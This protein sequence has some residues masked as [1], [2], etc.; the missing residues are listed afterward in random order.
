MVKVLQLITVPLSANGLALYPIRMAERMDSR[1]Q[2]DFLAS[3]AE[4]ELQARI[5]KMGSRL[6]LAPSRLRSP[7]A[8][9]RFV[10]KTIE[11][12][13]YSIVHAHGNSCTLALDLIAARRGGAKVRIA[14]SHNTFCRFRALNFLLRPAF[15]RAY[16]HALACSDS[17]GKWLFR[18][19]PFAILPNAI[20]ARAFAPDETVR[21]RIRREM[22]A[23]D[24]RIL[25]HI[26]NFTEAKNPLFF[27]D[28][29]AQL[30]RNY[31]LWM[32]GDGP[33]RAEAERLAREKKLE[34]TF[35]GARNDV[36]ALMQGADAFLMPS[37]YEGL[38]TVA[39]EAQASGL[40]TLLSENIARRTAFSSAA[41][42]L[43]LN[44]QLWTARI[45]A[46]PES[47]RNRNAQESAAALSQNGYDLNDAALSLEERYLTWSGAR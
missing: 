41:Q 47:G 31:A 11:K 14:H 33:L 37:L 23:G 5:E 44:A 17:A 43:P 38:P 2:V 15:D 29:M 46:L 45:Q 9:M 18:N 13:G 28:L 27:I 12:N 39:L 30:N 42:F 22:N 10:A 32:V 36:P 7:L 20:D 40:P 6:Y 16:T 4:P 21:A 19:R 1:V 35:T 26:G 24:K 3:Y 8:Y 25:L 34:I